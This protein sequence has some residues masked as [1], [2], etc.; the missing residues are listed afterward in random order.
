MNESGMD[1]YHSSVQ[2][3]KNQQKEHFFKR[4]KK[5]SEKFK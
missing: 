4:P 2:C 5:Q 1:V 3:W